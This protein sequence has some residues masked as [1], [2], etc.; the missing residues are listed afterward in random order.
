MNLLFLTETDI[1]PLQG[2]TERITCTLSE[3]F[4]RRGINCYL[5]YER[6]TELPAAVSF[7]EK[8]QYT[9][10]REEMQFAKFLSEKSIDIVISNLV[11]IHYKYR[12]LPVIRKLSLKDGAKIVA[13]LHAM[14]GEEL[15]GNSVRCSLYRI[16]HGDGLKENL[17]DIA[18]RL[19]PKPLL[20][21]L[22]KG[23]LRR[24]YRVLYDNADKVVL[25]SSRFYR[26]FA[27][28][29]GL[30][31]DGK[32]AAVGNALSFESFL[33][34]SGI[35]SKSKE[36]MMLSRMDEK[37]KR[38]SAALE[39]W[40]LVNDSGTHDDWRLTIVGGGRDLAYFKRLARKLDLRGVS[41]EGRQEDALPYYRRAAIFMMTSNYEGWGITL[42]EAQ[43]MGAVPIAFLSYA[44]LPE[45]ID[46]GK[47]GVVI[48]DGDKTEYVGKLIR[49][50]DDRSWR[51]SMAAEAIKS[52][53]RFTREIIC[54]KWVALFDDLLQ[55]RA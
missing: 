5:A 24:R 52:S 51:E 26:D 22:F 20:K 35:A 45:I 10:G 44:S 29:G 54:D 14:P 31:I 49:L 18:L 48:P 28:L 2:G 23:R 21:L 11:D 27:S 16:F 9:R 8:L 37:S 42:T 12:L 32:F 25:L 46:D 1:S 3:E 50:M 33:P 39:I 38:I 30:D 19:F 36:V 40:K 15:L 17:K 55:G 6:P 43:Q 13:C 47:N 53:R 41:F 34:E 4:S 7:A